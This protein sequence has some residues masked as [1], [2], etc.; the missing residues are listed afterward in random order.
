LL[1]HSTNL[2]GPGNADQIVMGSELEQLACIHLSDCLEGRLTGVIFRGG[3]P[4]STR[5]IRPMQLIVDGAYVDAGYL[6]ELTYT[7]VQAIEV[8]RDINHT[9][10]YGSYGANGLLL[11]TTKHGGEPQDEA[12]PRYGRGITTYFPKGY[13][14]AR[15]FYSPQYNIAQTNKQLA[16][17]R[18]TIFW[19]P[20]LKT[21]S[22][23][24]ADF[25]F[26]NAG[27][28]GTYRVVVEGIDTKGRIGRQVFRYQVR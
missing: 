18:T 15:T 27:S 16:D 6:G 28:K 9:A 11:I 24:K 1:Q 13:Y 22:D 20:E 14:K 2:N 5:S 19:Q 17:L 10:V 8:L 4:Y 7:E 23:G 26:F 12:E 3:V 25:S 21:G